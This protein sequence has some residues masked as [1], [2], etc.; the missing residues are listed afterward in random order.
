MALVIEYVAETGNDIKNSITIAN[1]LLEDETLSI[2]ELDSI[3]RYLAI[4]VREKMF[5]KNKEVKEDD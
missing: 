2:D 1:A 4:G 3:S 5:A